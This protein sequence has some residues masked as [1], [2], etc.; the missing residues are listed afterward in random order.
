MR[1]Q[2]K[3]CELVTVSIVTLR[4]RTSFSTET[5]QFPLCVRRILKSHGVSSDRFPITRRHF[6]AFSNR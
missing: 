1:A 6:H 3:D 5:L 4:L 2:I